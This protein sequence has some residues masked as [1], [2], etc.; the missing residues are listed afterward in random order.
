MSSNITVSYL[1]TELG[2]AAASLWCRCGCILDPGLM[3]ARRN[4]YWIT[5]T[6]FLT[7][8]FWKSTFNYFKT[9]NALWIALAYFWKKFLF[10]FFFLLL[11]GFWMIA[12]LKSFTYVCKKD[13]F[14]CSHFCTPLKVTSLYCTG[15]IHKQVEE[16]GTKPNL[17]PQ[18]K[19]A[20]IE[21]VI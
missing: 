3:F 21:F 19:S 8:Y 2:E 16:T 13:Q 17:I 11:D 4:L 6:V 18:I 9:L 20:F 1:C 10:F 5:K 12:P 14:N 7:L 15:R